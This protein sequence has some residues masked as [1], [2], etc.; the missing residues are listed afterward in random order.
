VL[1]NKQE[2][3]DIL[4]IGGG[5]IALSLARELKKKGAAKITLLERGLLGREASF[6]AAGMLSPQTDAAKPDDFFDF[7]REGR[8][9]YE[10]FAAG[11]KAE[12]GIDIELETSGTLS[13][14]FNETDSARLNKVYEW[15]TAAGLPVEKLGR[16]ALLELEPFLS[17]DV[18]AGVFFP[19]DNQVEN[20]LLVNALAHSVRRAGVS[21]FENTPAESL[22]TENGRI[23]GAATADGKF[24]APVVV[25]ATGAWSSFIKTGGDDKPLLIEVAPVR[26]QMISFH[27]AEKLFRR[28]IVS[29]D[30][31]LVPRMDGRILAGA[32]VENAGFDK[33]VTEEGVEF[34]RKSAYDISPKLKEFAISEKWAGLRPCATDKLPILGK[35]KQIE[36]LFIATAHFR[37][38]ILLA[39]LTA[40]IMAEQ[41]LEGKNSRYLEVFSPGRFISAVAA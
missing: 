22:L 11:L 20:R 18:C 24:F 30:G 3:S 33:T 6:A 7:C 2:F 29:A 10:N 27:P 1:S 17:P 8:G 37:N 21:V 36:G 14:S 13:V 9:L 38:G 31:Y 23:T 12:T 25:L 15:Q 28:V 40:R 19:R 26:G 41:I 35:Y 4:I 39:P 16:S 34:L 32:T 5:V